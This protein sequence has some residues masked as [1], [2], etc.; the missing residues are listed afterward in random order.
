[1]HTRIPAWLL[2]AITLAGLTSTTP[3]AAAQ[4]TV[5]TYQGR[6]LDGGTPANGTNYDMVFH[7]FDAPTNGTSWGTLGITNVTVSN[8]L[9]TV[10]LNFGDVFDGQPR[11]LESASRRMAAPPPP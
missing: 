10:P 1:M 9:F 11:W 4:D 7:L 2:A 3:R 5:F 8:G 6:L